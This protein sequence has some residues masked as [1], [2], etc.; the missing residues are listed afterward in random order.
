MPKNCRFGKGI[1]FQM[2][3]NLESNVKFQHFQLYSQIGNLK[4]LKTRCFTMFTLTW[5][6]FF[7]WPFRY[8]KQTKHLLGYGIWG[9]FPTDQQLPNGDAVYPTASLMLNPSVSVKW[10]MCK[11]P[12]A[13]SKLSY[14]NSKKRFVL[15]LLD[16]F[17]EE[18]YGSTV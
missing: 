13:W 10:T 1:A 12:W 2:L 16:I 18:I 11:Q 5:P 14:P 4:M 6:T 3:A 15:L 17:Q 7:R 9:G 8:W